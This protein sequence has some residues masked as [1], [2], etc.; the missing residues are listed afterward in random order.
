MSFFQSQ[1]QHG[2]PGESFSYTYDDG[3][4]HSAY[5]DTNGASTS[6]LEPNSRALSRPRVNMACKHCRQRKVRC[7]GKKPKCGLCT[8]LDRPCDY[9][10]VT[11]AENAILRDKKRQSK[12]RKNAEQEAARTSLCKHDTIPAYHPYRSNDAS[13]NRNSFSSS[14]SVPNDARVGLQAPPLPQVTASSS[15][16]LQP[17]LYD[18][19]YPSTSTSTAASSLFDV[20]TSLNGSRRMCLTTLTAGVR[21]LPTNGTYTYPRKQSM[22]D[23]TRAAEPR[24]RQNGAIG[25]MSGTNGS[26]ES[27]L[28]LVSTASA[29]NTAT[30]TQNGFAIPSLASSNSFRAEIEDNRYPRYMGAA[31]FIPHPQSEYEMASP[32]YHLSQSSNT[33]DFEDDHQRQQQQQHH[34]H[35]HSRYQHGYSHTCTAT[36]REGSVSPSLASPS[37]LA[38]M[39]ALER[40]ASSAGSGV[41]ASPAS[42]DIETSAQQQ[43]DDSSLWSGNG[44]SRVNVHEDV[45]QQFVYRH[46]MEEVHGAHQRV[47]EEHELNSSS[48]MRGIG[49]VDSWVNH[50]QAPVTSVR[51]VTP[52]TPVVAPVTAHQQVEAGVKD[53]NPEMTWYMQPTGNTTATTTI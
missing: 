1:P 19:R 45:A 21:S 27:D 10:K 5:R 44:L 35:H 25:T 20:G 16:V 43:H 49:M 3:H 36:H 30:P 7:D 13:V 48:G 38:A 6:Y 31:S 33:R 2:W 28:N 29:I 46:Q 9:V 37:Y 17:Y 51:P 42:H 41:S 24:C 34:H 15:S 40:A 26:G 53:W 8:R 22:E 11:A 23:H 39:P 52:M 14:L 4:H 32:T 47:Y 18:N 50:V 12:Q